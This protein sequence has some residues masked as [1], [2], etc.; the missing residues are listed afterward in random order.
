MKN[1]LLAASLVMFLAACATTPAGPMAI[2]GTTAA[3]AEASWER[4]LDT[5][6]P[7]TRMAL[8]QAM[9]QINLQGVDSVY[10]IAGNDDMKQLSISRIREQVDGMTADEIVALG[11]QVGTVKI[12]VQA[13]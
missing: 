9:I 6:D 1:S 2:D 7:A 11:E 12:E 8:L 10:D 5:V 4:M 3:T 13:D